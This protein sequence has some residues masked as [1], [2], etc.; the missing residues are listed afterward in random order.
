MYNDYKDFSMP[1]SIIVLFIPVLGFGHFYRRS[2]ENTKIIHNLC[3]HFARQDEQEGKNGKKIAQL[4]GPKY[5]KPKDKNM[6]RTKH[7]K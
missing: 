5:Q 3:L 6:G 1:N 7:V 2:Y 4:K